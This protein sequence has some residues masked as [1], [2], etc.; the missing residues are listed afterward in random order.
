MAR[1]RNHERDIA[2]GLGCVIVLVLV[3]FTLYVVVPCF[4]R[5][6]LIGTIQFH[7]VEPEKYPI[8]APE[9]SLL[10]AISSDAGGKI[11]TREKFSGGDQLDKGVKAI[12]EYYLKF[13]NDPGA[14]V[15]YE[16]K[17]V[18]TLETSA[19]LNSGQS[20][21]VKGC[22]IYR[23]IVFK[24]GETVAPPAVESVERLPESEDPEVQ[25]LHEEEFHKKLKENINLV[26]SPSSQTS[27]LSEGTPFKSKIYNLRPDQK[28][29]VLK[30]LYLCEVMELSKQLVEDGEKKVGPAELADMISEYNK[31]IEYVPANDYTNT[32]PYLAHYT[33]WL[34]LLIEQ[35]RAIAY[36]SGTFK[37]GPGREMIV[38]LCNLAS[39]SPD[40]LEAR[41][42]LDG[43]MVTIALYAI[44]SL[45]CGRSDEHLSNLLDERH[46]QQCRLEVLLGRFTKWFDK[47]YGNDVG[48]DAMLGYE[49]P[50]SAQRAHMAG[51]K[52]MYF[53]ARARL[54]MIRNQP[55]VH[56]LEK[57]S[58]AEVAPIALNLQRAKNV[59]SK[60][61]T[62]GGGKWLGIGSYYDYCYVMRSVAI[63]SHYEWM[64]GNRRQAGEYL[65]W[66]KELNEIHGKAKNEPKLDDVTSDNSD[67]SNYYRLLANSAYLRQ[68]TYIYQSSSKWRPGQEQDEPVGK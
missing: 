42:R 20:A 17:D 63:A 61:R 13:A 22:K 36:G 6:V 49:T 26:R 19:N 56:H 35:R 65:D 5:E 3:L 28:D 57:F 45:D 54:T 32:D 8:T 43:S 34:N 10:N 11:K 66:A 12:K 21:E 1:R 51:G 9:A 4:N 15:T 50:G 25:K 7:A 27:P 30:T 37:S 52:I 38:N 31:K 67:V 46:E 14:A 16:T 39:G 29:R 64:I 55:G 53:L 23:N 47:M 33:R 40:D 18:K 41:M 48:E 24:I 68:C 60:I 58:K 62:K 59:I 2:I 44:L